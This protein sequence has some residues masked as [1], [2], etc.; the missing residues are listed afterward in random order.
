MDTKQIGQNNMLEILKLSGV[1]GIFIAGVVGFYYFDSDLYSAIVLLASFVLGIVILF[2]TERG[3]IL[4]SF[5]LGSRVELRK[6]VWPT[7][8]E[9]IQTTIMVLIFAMIMGIFFW[10]L[11]MFLLWLT[12]FLTGQGV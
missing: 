6:V 10:L 7:R 5:I 11:D 1:L 8:E 2:Q 9:T 12:R 3:Q 4:K